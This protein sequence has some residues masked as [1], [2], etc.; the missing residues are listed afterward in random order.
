MSRCDEGYPCSRCGEPV[1]NLLES[2]L[3]V[4]YVLGEYEIH[5]LFAAPDCHLQC[6]YELAA[7]IKHEKFTPPEIPAEIE[8]PELSAAQR[9]RREEQVTAA[10]VRLREAIHLGL[11]IT[12]YPLPRAESGQH[13]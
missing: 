12:E 10:W 1:K 7:F 9:T 13:E 11:P 6:D 8:L 3:Y 5:E 2:S 4:R